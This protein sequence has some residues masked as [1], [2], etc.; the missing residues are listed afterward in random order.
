MTNNADKEKWINDVLDSAHGMLRASPGAGLFK[1]I[2]AELANP[3][4]AKTKPLPVKQW[5]AAAIFL[6]ALNIGSVVYY[7]NQHTRT[8]E[9]ASAN[10]IAGA[11]Q[12]ESTYN[13]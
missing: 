7:A 12:A 1:K 2:T 5:A 13:Y 4:L 9:S 3:Q 6:L 8:S 11:M 10:P